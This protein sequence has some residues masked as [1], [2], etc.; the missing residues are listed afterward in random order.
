M[1]SI[2]KLLYSI[3]IAA[4]LTWPTTAQAQDTQDF[5]YKVKNEW[6]AEV[7]KSTTLYLWRQPTEQPLDF[8]LQKIREQWCP[9]LNVAQ[10]LQKLEPPEI[11]IEPQQAI[12]AQP[13]DAVI[14]ESHRAAETSTEPQI[15]PQQNVASLALSTGSHSA[16][17]LRSEKS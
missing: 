8:S 16:P 10:M 12:Q 3:L 13:T 1:N 7:V 5:C 2:R 15:E 6:S 9:Q 14:T 11:V 4:S 17:P